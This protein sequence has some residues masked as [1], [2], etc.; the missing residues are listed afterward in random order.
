MRYAGQF[1]EIELPLPGAFR[2]AA[3]VE[4]VVKAFHARHK[5]LYTFD[6]PFRGTEF[7]TFRLK[8]TAPRRVGLQILPLAQGTTDP[9]AAFKRM[10]RCW[11]GK[12][13]VQTPC[14]DGE[15]VLAGQVFPG[16]AIIEAKATTVV[17]PAG[18]TCTMDPSGS[19]L[20]RR[21]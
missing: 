14:Y 3:D 2:S 9:K 5:E 8:A 18:F 7:L 15:R 20:L 6:L 17:I 12:E 11:F 10:R 1:H 16:P 13:W 21:N 4:D 19:Y